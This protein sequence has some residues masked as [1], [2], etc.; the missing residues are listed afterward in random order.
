VIAR[1]PFGPRGNARAD[2]DALAIGYGAQQPTGDDRTLLA[3][4]N[5]VEIS[6][7]RLVTGLSS[8]GLSCT[9]LVTC[10]H[11]EA[12]NTLIELEG[13]VPLAD[14]RLAALQDQLG[15]DLY[16]LVAVGGYAVPLPATPG[17]GGG[18]VVPANGDRTAAGA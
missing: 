15:R 3:T 16:R 17:F 18:I 5:A 4:E 11:A 14:P 9:F 8:A 12:A 2:G 7:G 10:A 1:L 13:Y 6:R